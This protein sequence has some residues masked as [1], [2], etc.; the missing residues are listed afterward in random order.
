MQQTACSTPALRASK[1][2]AV[3]AAVRPHSGAW[4][5][6]ALTLIC[7]VQGVSQGA[8]VLAGK[9][10]VPVGLGVVLDGPAH[11]PCSHTAMHRNTLSGASQQ[12]HGCCQWHRH[13]QP[14]ACL[15]PG[16]MQMFA[17]APAGRVTHRTSASLL[18]CAGP[19]SP[20]ASQQT[21]PARQQQHNIREIVST[22]AGPRRKARPCTGIAYI[23]GR[24]GMMQAIP[25]TVLLS[26][27]SH[28][29]CSPALA[30]LH[31]LLIRPVVQ[32][33]LEQA[34][35][36]QLEGLQDTAQHGTV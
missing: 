1:L 27:R 7:L 36:R 14:E 17:G 22:R 15:M 2:A 20:A 19:A 18:S 28:L 3:P 8:Q 23:N 4:G 35:T 24:C 29:P 12:S 9:E 11:V 26:G 30:L 10:D 6:A 21:T 5:A 25:R 32:G 13:A 33:D 34:A 16:R 31:G